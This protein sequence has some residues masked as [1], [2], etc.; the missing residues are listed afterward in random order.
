MDLEFVAA[1]AAVA[2]KA[3]ARHFSLVSA[4]GANANM[5]A[6]DLKPLHALLYTQTKGKVS[7][8]HACG[9]PGK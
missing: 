2:K 4:Q 9:A 6:S 5:W 3:G 8:Q 7:N 1:A